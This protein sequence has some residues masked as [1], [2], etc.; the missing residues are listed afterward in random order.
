MGS[1]A[2]LAGSGRGCVA[3]GR[4][5]QPLRRRCLG[6][7]VEGSSF[8]SLLSIL[9]LSDAKVYGPLIRA[10]LGTASQFCEALL[11][12]LGSV[13]ASS[14]RLLGGF[15]FRGGLVCKAH[16]LVH[17]STLGW[18]VIKNIREDLGLEDFGSRVPGS[19]CRLRVPGSGMKA[20]GFRC[21]IP[22]FGFCRQLREITPSKGA[23]APAPTSP[24]S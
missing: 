17:H 2:D 7:K 21:R 1:R 5:H 16:R 9:E 6:F 14:A 10:L 13:P 8:S 11:V 22:N 20:S 18:R 12:K 4:E 19:G 24:E 23:S 3:R 15:G